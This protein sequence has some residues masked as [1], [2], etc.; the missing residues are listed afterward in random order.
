MRVLV[1]IN[2]SWGEVDWLL[3]I[4]FH[5]KNEWRSK[6]WVYFTSDTIF[7]ESADYVDLKCMLETVS[8]QVVTP[9]TLGASD[10]IDSVNEPKI[11]SIDRLQEITGEAV[12]LIFHEFGGE[13]F[14]GI[15]DLFPSAQTV[16]FPHGTF[17]YKWVGS[18]LR[19]SY[20]R[21]MHFE[22]MRRDTVLL[23]GSELDREHFVSLTGLTRIE[24]VGHPKLNRAWVNKMAQEDWSDHHAGEGL[25]SKSEILFLQYPGRRLS[26]QAKYADVNRTVFHQGKRRG[27]SVI[28]RRHPRQ[29]P[30]QLAACIDAWPD[31]EVRLTK[32]SVL[33]SS[34]NILIAVCLPT[35]GCM[36]A[37]AAGIPVIEFFD[38]EGE[39]WPTF[40]PTSA[41]YT[42]IYRKTGL[43]LSAD[44]REQLEAEIDRLVD[45]PTYRKKVVTTQY[46][47][48]TRLLPIAGS[49]AS[50][51]ARLR[52]L[53]ATNTT[54]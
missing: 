34:R 9:A 46:Q 6:I 45:D 22:A 33:A 51:C 36:D 47:N 14:N 31:S 38:Y 28:V 30:A 53:V 27:L 48:L 44:T 25:A 13:N 12:D 23:V 2:E 37:I 32:L 49:S 26:S 7:E 16:A 40:V 5:I 1:I 43:V 39:Y 18:G 11:A 54:L 10:N 35:S 4:L 17:I 50:A 20:R 21:S 19:D 52:P 41:G 29:E 3:P 42:S 24:V 8:Q 15:L